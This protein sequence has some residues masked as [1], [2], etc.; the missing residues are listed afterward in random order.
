MNSQ[1][2]VNQHMS[3]LIPR[4]FPNRTNEQHIIDIFRRLHIGD[5]FKVDIIRK[6]DKRGQRYPIFQAFVYFSAWYENDIAYHFQQRICSEK[7][8][9]RVVYDDPWYWVV[10]ENTKRLPSPDDMRIM[11]LGYQLYRTQVIVN[12]QNQ[13]IE[14]LQ[15]HLY[16]NDIAV[17][18]AERV[19]HDE[20]PDQVRFNC[21][22]INP[23]TDDYE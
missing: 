23:W 7:K 14:Q 9:T 4:I 11:R 18:C 21:N 17:N 1:F 19:L 13:I 22:H 5:V 20:N 16:K 12:R 15:D 10:F 6:K 3:L 8:H 2:N